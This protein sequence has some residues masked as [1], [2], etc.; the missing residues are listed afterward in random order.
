MFS[1]QSLSYFNKI[2]FA[3]YLYFKIFHKKN[4]NKYVDLIKNGILPRPQY[5]LGLIL[6]ASEAV[7]LGYKKMSV[8]EFGCWECEGL[9]DME[10]YI[11][12]IQEYFKIEI[13]VYG[14]D[15]GSGIPKYTPNP[16]DRLYELNPG[17]YPLK[18]KE[19]IK[20]LKKTKMVW[21]DVKETCPNFLRSNNL[22]D[23]P[24]GFISFDLGIY[25]STHHALKIL[26][27]DSKFFLPRVFLYFDNFYFVSEDEGEKYAIKEFNLESK[28][29]ISQ[30]SELSE[31]LSLSWS[32]WSFLGKRIFQLHDFDHNKYNENYVHL[33][34]GMI[35]NR[36][37]KTL[38][39]K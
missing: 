2:N 17:D 30:I 31:Q 4:L 28:K 16:R 22:D 12:E 13:N 39:R 29:K 5:G 11:K 33:I 27:D 15:L 3:K 7:S 23:A 37:T 32:K 19:N 1:E 34:K 21:G 18:K 24:L 14:F 25:S 26:N 38:K 10:H 35:V 6:S 20:K 9:I 36:Y 8:I